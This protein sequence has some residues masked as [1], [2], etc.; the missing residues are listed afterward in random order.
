VLPRKVL[1]SAA[2]CPMRRRCISRYSRGVPIS[3]QNLQTRTKDFL[4]RCARHQADKGPQVKD[5]SRKTLGGSANSSI[6]SNIS[7]GGCLNA[8]GL[9]ASEPL[10]SECSPYKTILWIACPDE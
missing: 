2:T 7:G 6:S 10:A 3:R 1:R 9:L 8:S 5:A 4:V